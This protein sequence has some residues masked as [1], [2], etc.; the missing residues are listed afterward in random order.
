MKVG[1]SV[2]YEGQIYFVIEDLHNGMFNLE[3]IEKEINDPELP[4][5]VYQRRE[6]KCI[7]ENEMEVI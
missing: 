7:Y 2:L 6:A 4:F 3:Q 1:D 5:K